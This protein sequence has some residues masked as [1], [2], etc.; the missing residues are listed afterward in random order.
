MLQGNVNLQAPSSEG[1]RNFLVSLKYEYLAKPA[2]RIG[3][4][5]NNTEKE[6]VVVAILRKCQARCPQNETYSN[7][8]HF[9]TRLNAEAKNTLFVAMGGEKHY[10][11]AKHTDSL[12]M[13]ILSHLAEVSLHSR[14]SA[15]GSMMQSQ[16]L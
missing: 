3:I 2:A 13:A 15:T 1:F 4:L 10:D 6:D 8:Y 7:L 16:T 11:D 5:V 14:V 9:V 12:L